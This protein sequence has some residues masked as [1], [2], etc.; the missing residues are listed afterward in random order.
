[1]ASVVRWH[2][3]QRGMLAMLV[4]T[5]ERQEIACDLGRRRRHGI[6]PL[7][8]ARYRDDENDWESGPLAW[9][10]QDSQVANRSIFSSNPGL[11]RCLDGRMGVAEICVPGIAAQSKAR[12]PGPGEAGSVRSFPCPSAPID[13][14]EGE[15]L[16]LSPVKERAIGGFG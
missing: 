11:D 7:F 2:Y 13:I 8:P 3:A 9:S 10:H 12:R 16:R 6:P 1:M 14:K 5:W 4:C 15:Y